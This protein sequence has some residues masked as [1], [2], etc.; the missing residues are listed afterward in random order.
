M[1]KKI[2]LVIIIAAWCCGLVA[3][4]LFNSAR[5]E[6]RKEQKPDKGTVVAYY[7]H[8]NFRCYSCFTIEQYAKEAIEKYFPEQ[9]K[10]GRLSFQPINIEEKGNEHFIQDY[11]LY[12]RSLILAVF[13]NGKQ[14]KWINLEKVWNY[15]RDRDAFYNYV[16]TEVEKYLKHL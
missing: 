8:G 11:Q 14:V 3:N 6:T 9:L 5:A 4:S 2:H 16:K 10:N 1:M 15:I 7:F 12:T 13:K